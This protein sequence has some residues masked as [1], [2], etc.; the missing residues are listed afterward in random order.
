MR[1]LLLLEVLAGIAVLV[2]SRP[3]W[4]GARRGRRGRRCAGSLAAVAGFLVAVVAIIVIIVITGPSPPDVYDGV[5]KDALGIRDVIIT[6]FPFPPAAALDWAIAAVAAAALA[7]RL[8]LF[9]ARRR[10]PVDLDR[11]C[12]APRPD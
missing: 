6:P 8:R 3:I 12:C 5:V 1:E 2:A 11:A 7:S 10:R 9:A 4:P